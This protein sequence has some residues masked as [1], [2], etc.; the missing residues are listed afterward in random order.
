MTFLHAQHL[1]GQSVAELVAQLGAACH[2]PVALATDGVPTRPGQVLVVPPGYTVRIHRDARVGVKSTGEEEPEASIDDAFTK[3][4]EVFGRDALAI[5][6]SGHNTD[7]IAGAKALH[8]A[9]GRV[10]VE[11]AANEYA[12]M[13]HEITAAGVVEYSGTPQELAARLVEKP[14]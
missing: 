9:G 6:F 1:R 3:A 10:W 7:S 11:T 14:A 2:L 4:A 8:A 5:V 13:V 12:D